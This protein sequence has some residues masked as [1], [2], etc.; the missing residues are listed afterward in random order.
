MTN[1]KTR[2]ER[3]GNEIMVMTQVR[4]MHANTLQKLLHVVCKVDDPLDMMLTLLLDLGC[5]TNVKEKEKIPNAG[6]KSESVVEGATALHMCCGRGS[7]AC[8]EL[9]MARG[10]DVNALDVSYSRLY[11]GLIMRCFACCKRIKVQCTGPQRVV[12]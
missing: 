10:A 5:D 11:H 2:N 4:F 3:K 1:K 8:A 9:L 6:G 7:R 12:R